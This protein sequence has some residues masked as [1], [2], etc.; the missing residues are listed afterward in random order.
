MS[1]DVSTL[2]ENFEIYL[3]DS[4]SVMDFTLTPKAS[5]TMFE[6]LRLSFWDG[7]INDMQLNDP[8]GQRT[9]ILFS[10]VQINPEIDADMFTFDIPDGVD[11]ISE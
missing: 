7:R 2:A 10:N 6:E 5:D 3:E 4:G 9:N 8:I 1:G 11:V